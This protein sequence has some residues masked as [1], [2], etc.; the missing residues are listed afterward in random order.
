[1][2]HLKDH[3]LITTDLSLSDLTIYSRDCFILEEICV[4]RSLNA[5]KAFSPCHIPCPRRFL[6]SFC[7]DVSFWFVFPFPR[8]AK[9]RLRRI[10]SSLYVC[11]LLL[12]TELLTDLGLKS[13]NSWVFQEGVQ[14]L[15][16][17]LSELIFLSTWPPL[18]K[19]PSFPLAVKLQP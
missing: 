1:M 17:L 16:L 2:S 5:I 12:C 6:T 3:E 13:I 15:K 4:A 11:R 14:F 19:A 10:F 18:W 8:Q 7:S 9:V